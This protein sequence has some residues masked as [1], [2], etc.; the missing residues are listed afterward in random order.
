MDSLCP[1]THLVVIS[2]SP[3]KWLV[4]CQLG[5]SP[6][7]VLILTRKAK[8]KDSKITVSYS[9]PSKMINQN[10]S[11]DGEEGWEPASPLETSSMQGHSCNIFLIHRS[12][13]WSNWKHLG[14]CRPLAAQLSNNSGHSCYAMCGIIVRV[15]QEGCRYLIYGHRFCKC[16]LL[17][18]M[19]RKDQGKVTFY[20]M[21][22]NIHF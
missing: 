21:G 11:G 5:H 10:T 13:C 15:D 12:G 16:I 22:N 2:L 8:G 4:I 7:W 17:K 9:L 3:S 19:I 14:K 20:V 18:I 6:W 1:Q